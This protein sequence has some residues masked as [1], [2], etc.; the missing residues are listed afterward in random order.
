VRL[1]LNTRE[2]GRVTIVRCSGRVIAGAETESLHSH[3][4]HLLRDRKAIVLNLGEVEFVDSS[5]L[6]AMVRALTSARQLHGDVKL[7]NVP[8]TIHKVLK[9]THLVKL[10]DI[11]D[12][13][14]NAVAAFYR[15]T[16]SWEKLKTTGPSILCIDRSADVLAYLRELLRRAGYQAYTTNNLHDSLIL[17]R[18]TPPGLLVLGADLMA[19]Q[20]TQQAFQLACAKLPVVELGAEF[21]TL[22]AGE[23]ASGLLE[24]IGTRLSP[25][26]KLPS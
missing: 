23:A 3:I 18:V 26:A 11:Q 6:G 13:E 8:E 15:L 21:S 12:S 7:C 10:F 24:K 4:A 9:M 22:D 2:V 5:G 25:P 14:E 17:M 1:T 19:S 16:G 20:A